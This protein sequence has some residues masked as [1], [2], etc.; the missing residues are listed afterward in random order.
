LEAIAAEKAGI[1]SPFVPVVVGS[2]P[3]EA[4]A[5]IEAVADENHSPVWRYGKEITLSAGLE[6]GTI[7]VETPSAQH[8]GLRPGIP[9]A[10]QGHNL[11]LAV[12]AMD[13]AGAS[14][15]LKGLVLGSARAVVPGRFQR[16]ERLGRTWILDGAHN[17][18]AAVVL[19]E[20]LRNLFWKWPG[21]V[22]AKPRVVL[23][24]NMVTGHEPADFYS[25]LAPMVDSAHVVPIDFPRAQPPE[26]VA[27]TLASLGV[28]V[29]AC[30]GLA[31]GVA[32]AIA[33]TS[34]SD[35][36]LVTG[37]FYLVGELGRAIGVGG[38]E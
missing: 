2:M 8:V 9:G 35:V 29:A 12:A 14:R 5:V 27:E 4:L 26:A 17:K 6:T 1:I 15:T 10:M 19:V 11:A 25:V 28:P 18:D 3:P 36:I 33:D 21:D 13:A 32:A 20:S 38:D 34:D 23:V 16:V 24:T 7:T 31:E 30:G 22:K 37:S